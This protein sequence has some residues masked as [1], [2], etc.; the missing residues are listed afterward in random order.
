[1]S[2][3][4]KSQP[5]I[6]ETDQGQE[7]AFNHYSLDLPE[8][9]TTAAIPV[10]SVETAIEQTTAL[11]KTVKETLIKQMESGTAVRDRTGARVWE[12]KGSGFM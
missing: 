12:R 1:M 11:L 8:T 2:P 9:T 7:S 6:L 4:L 5:L 3:T 10:P